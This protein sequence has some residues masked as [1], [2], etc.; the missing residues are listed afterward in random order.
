MLLRGVADCFNGKQEWVIV[1]GDDAMPTEHGEVI[2]ETQATIATV[3]LERPDGM[4]EY[5]WL[6]DVIHRQAHVMQQQAP[7][8]VRRYTFDASR[9][10]HPRRRHVMLIKRH[11]WTPWT[12]EPE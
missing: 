2:H 1:T 10:W 5:E 3:R 12:P 6:T 8:S 4:S 9:V 7:Q 11:G